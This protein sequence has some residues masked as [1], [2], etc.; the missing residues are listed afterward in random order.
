MLKPRFSSFIFLAV[1]SLCLFY[2]QSSA[3]SAQEVP[4]IR[5][6]L[7]VNEQFCTGGQPRLEHLAKLKADGG[8]SDHQSSTAQRTSRLRR[9][10]R[11][12][13]AGAAL[14]QHPRRLRRA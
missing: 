11:S 4:P 12:Q 1:S 14:L 9:R 7:Q 6:F 3:Q 8:E 2:S 13:E 10:S 5:N